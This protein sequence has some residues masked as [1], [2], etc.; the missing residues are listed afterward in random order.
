MRGSSKAKLSTAAIFVWMGVQNFPAASHCHLV[1]GL[2]SGAA[3]APTSLLKNPKH[4]SLNSHACNTQIH[5][6]A[7]A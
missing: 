7:N 4:K 1:A 2:P 6:E 3:C 5:S